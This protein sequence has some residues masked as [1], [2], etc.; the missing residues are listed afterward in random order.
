[1]DVMAWNSLL[2]RIDQALQQDSIPT[3]KLRPVIADLESQIAQAE[4]ELAGQDEPALTQELDRLMKEQQ[5]IQAM[6]DQARALGPQRI[7]TDSD[8]SAAEL[9][10]LESPEILDT[11]KGVLADLD[12]QAQELLTAK[13]RAEGQWQ[14]HQEHLRRLD[15]EEK[16]LAQREKQ[17]TAALAQLAQRQRRR[18]LR[19]ECLATAQQ[20]H[21]LRESL[22]QRVRQAKPA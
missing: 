13:T 19:Q 5:R 20:T 15:E 17:V 12:R 6:L 11:A 18:E 9:A 8:L 4:H 14:S 2:D 3:D 21:A 7:Q 22:R 16:E 10:R 1:M